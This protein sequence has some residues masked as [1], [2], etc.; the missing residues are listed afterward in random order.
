MSKSKAWMTIS[1]NKVTVKISPNAY[2]RAEIQKILDSQ[3]PYGGLYKMKIK[4]DDKET[5]WI[6]LTNTQVKKLKEIV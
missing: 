1:G 4:S 6:N 5:K 2:K 3:R